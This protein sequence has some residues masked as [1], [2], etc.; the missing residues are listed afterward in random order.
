MAELFAFTDGA[1]S[2]NPGPGGWGVLMQAKDGDTVLKERA[3]SG[4]E[5][6]TTDN[7]MELL[8]AIHALETLDRPAAI[9]IVTDGTVDVEG[10]IGQVLADA[11]EK[12]FTS[13]I[14]ITVNEGDLVIDALGA[15]VGEQL[16]QHL[17]VAAGAERVPLTLE[18]ALQ[19]E[20]V[21]DLT[22][23]RDRVPPLGQDERL[24]AAAAGVDDRQAAMRETDTSAL[25]PPFAGVVRPAVVQFIA[26]PRQPIAVAPRVWRSAT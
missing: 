3:L 22:V 8:A 11:P 19:L 25:R 23:E 5:A 10:V 6:E 21:V 18:F 26:P 12:A 2:G 24:V 15:I 7:R 9:T 13:S 4:G 14:D 16:Q 20:V 17:G 1:C